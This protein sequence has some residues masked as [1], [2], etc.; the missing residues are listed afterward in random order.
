[1]SDQLVSM[2]TERFEG[3]LIVH[4]S[5][6]IDLSNASR[7][8]RELEVSVAGWPDVVIDLTQIEYLDSQGL[9]LIRQLINDAEANG[10]SLQLVAPP[11]S[12]ARQV[13]EIAKLND[14]I[15]IR[16]SLES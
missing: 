15:E 9:R 14:Y 11:S 3:S 4:L 10:T 16:D 1:M 2:R 8:H 7:I 5:G 13:L 6:E 12:F